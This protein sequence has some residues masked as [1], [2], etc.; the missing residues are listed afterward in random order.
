MIHIELPISLQFLHVCM[1]G[2]FEFVDNCPLNNSEYSLVPFML[3]SNP[4]ETVSMMWIYVVTRR[5]RN[6]VSMTGGW[7]LETV[8]W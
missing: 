1:Q 3:P 7:W 5:W 6:S 8:V 2:F 4:P